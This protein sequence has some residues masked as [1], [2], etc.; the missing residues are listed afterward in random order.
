MIYLCRKPHF[1]SQ[2]AFHQT[3]VRN[4]RTRQTR[5]HRCCFLRDEIGDCGSSVTEESFMCVY[6]LGASFHQAKIKPVG[7]LRQART[8]RIPGSA[9]ATDR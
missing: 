7:V 6:E 9:G 4:S 1:Q 2:Q 3:R 8:F 5:I